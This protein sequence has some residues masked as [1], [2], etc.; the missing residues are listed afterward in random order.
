MKIEA[1]RQVWTGW[2]NERRSAFLELLS[3][4]KNNHY[5]QSISA[6]CSPPPCSRGGPAALAGVLTLPGAHGET[7][8]NLKNDIQRTSLESLLETKLIVSRTKFWGSDD[9][10]NVEQNSPDYFF[11]LLFWLRKCV[12][13]DL[14]RCGQ[15]DS[16]LKYSRPEVIPNGRLGLSDQK[17]RYQ[18]LVHMDI[19]HLAQYSSK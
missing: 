2:T 9:Q 10:I 6:Y 19:L 7:S 1:S 14:S 8:S 4:A 18:F 5:N 11:F 3:E 12:G 13:N 17:W 15:T 16:F